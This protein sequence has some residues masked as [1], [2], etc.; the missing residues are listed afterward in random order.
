MQEPQ[1]QLLFLPDASTLHASPLMPSRAARNVGSREAFFSSP[2]GA[3]KSAHAFRSTNSTSHHSLVSPCAGFSR[4]MNHDRRQVKGGPLGSCRKRSGRPFA[5]G[6]HLHFPPRRFFHDVGRVL[7]RHGELRSAA[8]P[9]TP[10]STEPGQSRVEKH[11][12]SM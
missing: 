6:G 8:Q 11:T 5:R 7:S 2:R 3:R 12:A 10:F 1:G 4:L 9:C